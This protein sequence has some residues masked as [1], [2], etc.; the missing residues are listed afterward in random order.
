MCD[1]PRVLVDLGTVGEPFGIGFMIGAGAI[2][3]VVPLRMI[4]R[5]V[6]SL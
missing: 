3:T 1:L 2:L 4:L 5:W 6:Q